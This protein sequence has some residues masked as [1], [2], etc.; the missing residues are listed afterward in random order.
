LKS[1]RENNLEVPNDIEV[2]GFDNLKISQF[3][4]PSLSTVDV[5]KYALGCESTHILMEHIKDS[6]MEYENKYLKTRLI[7]RESTSQ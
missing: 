6:N 4:Y 5:P 3:I 7:F 2:F 1:L